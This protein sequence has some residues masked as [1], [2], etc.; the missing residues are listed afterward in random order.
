M[1]Q[2]R[3]SAG[4][5]RPGHD[6]RCSR[7]TAPHGLW[8]SPLLRRVDHDIRHLA[9]LRC[10]L[11]PRRPALIVGHAA[12]DHLRT[13]RGLGTERGRR[14]RRTN[15]RAR[16]HPSRIGPTSGGIIAS[17]IASVIASSTVIVIITVMV[18]I[19]VGSIVLPA[20][21]LLLPIALPT[22]LLLLPIALPVFAV[23]GLGGLAT[24]L[25]FL[26]CRLATGLRFLGRRTGGWLAG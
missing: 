19:I 25:R 13:R 6:P 2:R 1:A 4:C 23:G 10:R 17:V 20:L 22:L 26:G 8:R 24:G 12:H 11:I 18:I 5:R 3:P 21:L 16:D 9:R 14:H 15:D 7:G